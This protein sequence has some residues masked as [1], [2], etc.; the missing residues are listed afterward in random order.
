MHTVQRNRREPLYQRSVQKAREFPLSQRS[1][2]HHFETAHGVTNDAA[3]NVIQKVHLLCKQRQKTSI[4]KRKKSSI[5]HLCVSCN[6]IYSR[7]RRHAQDQPHHEGDMM[8]IKY[9]FDL[10]QHILGMV[11]CKKDAK[12]DN[13]YLKNATYNFE[14]LINKYMLLKLKEA[15]AGLTRSITEAN[16]QGNKPRLQD[17][18]IKTLGMTYA[19]KIRDWLFS[20]PKV[21][22]AK[23]R[24][25]RSFP[26]IRSGQEIPMS[27]CLS[28]CAVHLRTTFVN[29]SRSGSRY[30]EVVQLVHCRLTMEGTVAGDKPLR[31]SLFG[32]KSRKY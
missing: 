29:L 12:S 25:V 8:T 5:L 15:D 6:R 1:L 10:P 26:S 22:A 7:K 13:F 18:C 16:V 30:E 3:K 20:C 28:L 2:K 23:S 19:T 24:T 11:K 17:F 9:I 14:E 21:E 32:I 4:T 27:L 31:Q